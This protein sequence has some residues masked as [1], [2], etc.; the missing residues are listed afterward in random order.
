VR[1]CSSVSEYK[2]P[3][4][5]R[6]THP[7]P[8][9]KLFIKQVPTIVDQKRQKAKIKKTVANKGLGKMWAEEKYINRKSRIKQQIQQDKTQ[10]SRN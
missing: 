3:N 4:R 7:K 5:S 6:L 10:L 8:N 9:S 2:H 1:K